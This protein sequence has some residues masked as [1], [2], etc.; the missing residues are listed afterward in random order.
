MTRVVIKGATLVTMDEALGDLVGA[1]LLVENGR[2]GSVGAKIEADGAEIVDGRGRIVIP[3]LI[4]AHMH[5]WQTALRGLAANW[6]LLEYFKHMHAGLATV[7]EPQDLYIATLVGAVLQ[8]VEEHR[9]VVV[10]GFIPG[11]ADIGLDIVVIDHHLMRGEQP[12]AAALVNPNRPD[13]TSGQGHLAAAGV[14]FVLLAA[15]AVPASAI[16]NIHV[17]KR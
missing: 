8:A 10:D 1:D 5:T 17:F 12:P 11:A 3:G 2:I 9:V 14:T 4:N 7:F 15:L 13:D 16:A 6:T